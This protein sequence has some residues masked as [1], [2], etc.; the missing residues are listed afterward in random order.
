[1]RCPVSL[2]DDI[3]GPMAPCLLDVVLRKGEGLLDACNPFAKRRRGKRAAVARAL[4]SKEE[5]EPGGAPEEE[6]KEVLGLED[7]D[8]G[9]QDAALPSPP[10]AQPRKPREPE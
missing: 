3:V 4:P 2:T 7:E 8:E 1:M 5:D 6:E 10:A 9:E